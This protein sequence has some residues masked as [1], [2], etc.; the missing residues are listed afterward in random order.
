MGNCYKGNYSN[1]DLESNKNIKTIKQEQQTNSSN[2]NN[3]LIISND[4]EIENN[5]NILTGKQQLSNKKL[6][7][8]IKQSKS[9]KEGEELI[10]TALGLLNHSNK[11]QDGSVIF[12]DINVNY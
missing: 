3:I 2:K 4:M 11:F 12:G 1:C 5:N 8:I 10:I 7:L 9:L 6:K